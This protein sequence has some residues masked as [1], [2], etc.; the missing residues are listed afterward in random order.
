MF[1]Q[2][3]I[4]FIDSPPIG[5]PCAIKAVNMHNLINSQVAISGTCIY[6]VAKL[7]NNTSGIKK[8]PTFSN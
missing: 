8:R 4:E 6:L 1:V 2:S 5:A 7:A 3:S